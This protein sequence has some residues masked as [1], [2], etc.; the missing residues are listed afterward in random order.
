MDI[1]KRK[2]RD[3]VLKIHRTLVIFPKMQ[4]DRRVPCTKKLT[5]LSLSCQY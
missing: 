3:L 2:F 5:L 4:K 1:D